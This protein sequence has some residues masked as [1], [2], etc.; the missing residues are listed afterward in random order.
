MLKEVKILLTE[1]TKINQE[2]FIGLLEGSGIAIDIAENG[3]EAVEKSREK[4]YSLI[5]MDIEMPIMD[6]YEATRIIRTEN[7]TVPIIALTTN[8]SSQD[9]LRTKQFGMN[10]HLSK[11]IDLDILYQAF[12]KYIA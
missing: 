9:K 7:S 3:K 4:K 1:D 6:G 12:S 8:N 5:V 11:P 2:I 10:A